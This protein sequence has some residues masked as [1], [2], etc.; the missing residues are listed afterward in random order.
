MAQISIFLSHIS[1]EANLADIV[2][3]HVS[4]DFIGLAKVFVSTQASILVGS[5]WLDEVTSA[6]NKAD[7]H[8]VLA[9]PESVERKWINFEAGAAHVRRVP[10]IPLCHS[11]LAPAQLPVPLSE[12]EGLVLSGKGEFERFYGAI[13]ATL[14]SNL[15][16]VD[17]AAYAREV[18]TFEQ[19]YEKQRQVATEARPLTPGIET[20]RNPRALCISSPQFMQLG[21]ENQIES[22]LAAFPSDVDHR[23]EFDSTTVRKSLS[24]E[25][26]DIVHV[27][28][29]VCPRSGDVY[30]SDVDP[31]SGRPIL[32]TQVDVIPADDFVSLLHAAG[33]QLAVITSGDSLALATSLIATCH[34]VAARDMISAKMAAAWVEAFY[35]RLSTGD[36]SE[37]LEY[38]INVSGAP[39]R[40]YAR[41][42]DS[43][44]VRFEAVRTQT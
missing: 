4:R 10:I 14:G 6:L 18:V 2:E 38:A 42:P 41:Q 19:D 17:Y 20:V 24:E 28:A 34:V 37:A 35:R 40:L 3:H 7:L 33:T 5:K 12:S 39:M 30:F 13:A 22:V 31:Q 8:V 16:T 25:K 21:L 11:G 23:R 44:D 27:A 15:P 26:F 1:C 29:F 36:L 43:V 32:Q 9:S